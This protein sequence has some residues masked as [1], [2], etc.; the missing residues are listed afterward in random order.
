MKREKRKE[1][2]RVKG[3]K[4]EN[5]HSGHV[6]FLDFHTLGDRRLDMSLKYSLDL[7][8][9]ESLQTPLFKEFL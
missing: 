5:P 1:K 8:S 9:N 3:E 2:E 4:G 6:R 7:V